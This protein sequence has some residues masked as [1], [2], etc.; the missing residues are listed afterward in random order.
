MRKLV[1]LFCL[2]LGFTA[3]AQRI[4]VRKGGGATESA[5][6][7]TSSSTDYKL[8]L[9]TDIGAF[10]YGYFPVEAEYM[11]ADWFTL[12]AGVGLTTKNYLRSFISESYFE[13]ENSGIGFGGGLMAR[14]FF[15][16]DAMDEGWYMAIL[17][18]RLGYNSTA[19]NINPYFGS[20]TAPSA[21]PLTTADISRTFTEVG[22]VYGREYMPSDRV[23]MELFYGFSLTSS[24]H[25]V[26]S[27]ELDGEYEMTSEIEIPLFFV[28]GFKIAFL[29]I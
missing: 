28:F 21:G 4:V 29:A 5:K 16:G 19:T 15:D 23:M 24:K 12:E 6:A 2:L 25:M 18:R 14:F 26:N 17:Y 13:S 1:L 22:V 10:A 9:G 7:R 3:A 27:P 8:S 11:L 20:P